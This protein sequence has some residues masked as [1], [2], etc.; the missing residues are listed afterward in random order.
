MGNVDQILWNII[1][2]IQKKARM[3]KSEEDW[4]GL[5]YM[6]VKCCWAEQF[7]KLSSFACNFKLMSQTYSIT[8]LSIGTFLS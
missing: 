5:R 3:A 1:Q 8:W 6:F 4:N 7:S 2:Q